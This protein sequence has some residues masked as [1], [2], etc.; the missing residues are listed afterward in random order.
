LAKHTPQDVRNLALCGQM[1][2]GKTMLAEAMLHKAGE[3]NRLG[4]VADGTTVSDYDPE[5]KKHQYSIN[6]A[7]VH[8]TH[9]GKLFNV[10]D[11]PGGVDFF[12]SQVS[13]I[14]GA[15]VAVL[16]VNAAKGVEVITRKAWDLAG[17]LHRPRMVAITRMDSENVS[18]SE[19]LGSVQKALGKQCLP[20]V[21]PQ[22]EGTDFRGVADVFADKVPDELADQAESLRSEITECVVES[23]DALMEK[24]LEQGEI[25][26][27]EFYAALTPAVLQGTVVPVFV[28]AAEKDLGVAEFMDG[29][30]ACAPSPVHM[31]VTARKG[32]GEEAEEV[33]VDSSVDGPLLAQVFKTVS[34]PHVGKLCFVRIWSGALES[35]GTFELASSGDTDK[36]AQ[37]YRHQGE[38]H[39]EVPAGACG[40]IVTVGKVEALGTGETLRAPG[41]DLVLPSPPFPKPMVGL[42]VI[43]K[44]RGD[45]QKIS[46]ALHRLCDEDPSI[47]AARDPQTH[48]LVVR[49]M[50]QLHLEVMLNRLKDRFNVEVTTKPPKIPYQE[51]V[52]A[53]AEAH[54]RH[55][56]QTGGAGQ[57][58]EVFLRVWPTERGEGFQFVDSI[59]G[60]AISQQFVGSTE[61]G[62]RQALDKGPLAGFPVVD[63]AVEVY[64]GKEHPVDSKD[65]A[66]QTAGRNAFYEAMRQAKPV[67]LEPIVNIEIVFPPAY[68]GDINS[69]ISSRRG[70][71]TGMEMVGDVQT[72]RAEVPLAEVADYGSTL[73]AITQGEGF[74]SMELSHYEPVPSNVAQTVIARL[75]AE[76]EQE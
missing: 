45:E 35:K 74:F 49:G 9:A 38:K 21:L 18:F 60:G 16:C 52:T 26:R 17:E 37:L 14:A 59:V 31:R 40:D 4:S 43:P 27:D 29:V 19:A 3:I 71:P 64:D 33:T 47:E 6:T 54:Y 2:A 15:D 50:G 76:A 10:L 7:L 73:K 5:E 63:V 39:E 12:G 44:S 48:E 69:D 11:A 28:L 22:G 68:T 53:K 66:F 46:T 51:T 72:L 23:D 42:A 36:V 55:K 8:C 30:A 20:F 57:F 70:R 65:I 34:D 1:G 56:K 13:A 75:K 62:V 32:A 58:A 61:K 41:S 24:Y 67:M 25:S